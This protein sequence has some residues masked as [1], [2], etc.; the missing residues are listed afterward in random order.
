MGAKLTK[1]RIAITLEA[2]RAT[3][4]AF[5]ETVIPSGHRSGNK[6]RPLLGDHSRTY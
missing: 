6:W 1:K 4:L 3:L 5:C 2:F